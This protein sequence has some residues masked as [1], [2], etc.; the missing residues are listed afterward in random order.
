M[1]NQIELN[2]Y[3]IPYIVDD[4]SKMM[5]H[6]RQCERMKRNVRD[7]EPLKLDPVPV[8]GEFGLGF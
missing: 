1:I 3:S 5:A 2:A 7:C 6:V 4:L 8:P